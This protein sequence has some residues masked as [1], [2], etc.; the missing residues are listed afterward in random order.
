M[1]SRWIHTQPTN[2]SDE[3]SQAAPHIQFSGAPTNAYH[4]LTRLNIVSESG[5]DIAQVSGR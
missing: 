4:T 3:G 1:E 2:R 5:D